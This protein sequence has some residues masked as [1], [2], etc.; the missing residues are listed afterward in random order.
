R[1]FTNIKTIWVGP[2]ETPA[3]IPQSE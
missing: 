2:A 1:E 3:P